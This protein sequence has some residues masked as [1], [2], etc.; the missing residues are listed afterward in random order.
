MISIL[1]AKEEIPAIRN[2]EF[3]W[4]TVAVA[5]DFFQNTNS[6]CA[7]STMT[8]NHDMRRFKSHIRQFCLFS[9]C[10]PSSFA[11]LAII[12]SLTRT[13]RRIACLKSFKYL[14]EFERKCITIHLRIKHSHVI[15]I[16]PLRWNN[17]WKKKVHGSNVVYYSYIYPIIRL[18]VYR[19]LNLSYP[20][21]VSALR[22][23]LVKI[24]Y[25]LSTVA[26]VTLKWNASK[27]I[28]REHWCNNCWFWF[29]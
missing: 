15:D 24:V 9:V 27:R 4:Y 8:T 23:F 26:F 7:R 22:Y 19:I 10:W 13:H 29:S 25:L 2:F 12:F 18:I 1:E 14:A 11:F 3:F 20:L 6:K 16:V 17:I 5:V 21:L 28:C